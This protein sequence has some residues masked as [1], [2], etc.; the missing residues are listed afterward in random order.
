M[1]EEP[2]SSEIITQRETPGYGGRAGGANQ[3]TGMELAISRIGI[4]S[5]TG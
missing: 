2:K 3:A 1:Y 5:L 4:F